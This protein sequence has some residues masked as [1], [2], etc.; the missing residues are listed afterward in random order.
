MSRKFSD[1][2]EKTDVAAKQFKN[3]DDDNNGDDDSDSNDSEK[4]ILSEVYKSTLEQ[5]QQ[6]LLNSQFSSGIDQYTL[7]SFSYL[8]PVAKP[9]LAE[10][11]SI[12]DCIDTSTIDRPPSPPIKAFNSKSASNKLEK[13]P[14]LIKT[15]KLINATKTY[16]SS[17]SARSAVAR[18]ESEILRL[19]EE[20]QHVIISQM[21]NKLVKQSH[22]S[23][24]I[25]VNNES[26]EN[27]EKPSINSDETFSHLKASGS[28]LSNL[29]V[30]NNKRTSQK[31]THFKIESS[32]K[33]SLL[34][35]ENLVKKEVDS[36]KAL[37]NEEDETKKKDSL[38][39]A[40]NKKKKSFMQGMKKDL[41]SDIPLHAIDRKS[42]Q[43]FYAQSQAKTLCMNL[44][45]EKEEEEED[46]N[47]KLKNLDEHN[48]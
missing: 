11:T 2:Q 6:T 36:F 39:N 43:I 10:Y 46:L 4:N 8:H 25:T 44:D 9:P 12:T 17:E 48:F 19:A 40:S 18:Q 1:T 5:Q 13:N 23:D 27:T 30:E 37:Y 26:N 14:N 28:S 21:L 29:D 15:G 42:S 35:S 47:S 38:L 33:E 31:D 24:A 3:S 45:D 7:H 16:C 34:F 20:S 32:S 22:S 41:M